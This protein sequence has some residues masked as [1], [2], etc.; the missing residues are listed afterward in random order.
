MAIITPATYAS[1]YPSVSNHIANDPTPKHQAVYVPAV[2]PGYAK[3][4]YARNW[5]RPLPT[6][7][8]SG[9]LNFLDP[10]NSLLRLSHALSSAGQALNQTQPCIL[11]AR[12]RSATVLI[13]D[14]GGYQIASGRLRINGD[15]DRLRILRWLEQHSDYAMTLDVPTGSVGRPDYPFTCTRDCL[16]ATLDHLDFFQR[17]RVA[18]E[19]SFLNVLQGNNLKEADAWY[20]AVKVYNFEGWAFAGVLRQDLYALCHR[21]LTMAHENQ[22]QHKKWIHILGTGTL[23]VAVLL[24][25]LQRSINRWINPNLR[26][27]YDTSSAFRSLRWEQAY[28]FPAFSSKAMTMQ[29][30]TVPDHMRFL[31]SDV[32]W[33]WPSPLGDRMIMGDVCFRR[34]PALNNRR[35]QQSN[36]Y[37]VHHNLGALCWGI[38]TANRVFDAEYVTGTHS[39]A[40][41]VARAAWAIDAV[42]KSRCFDTLKRHRE[43]FTRFTGASRWDHGDYDRDLSNL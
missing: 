30:E 1:E 10:S 13:G 3:D 26:I 20:D 36:H 6:G 21:I 35:D 40:R 14:S 17:N 23:E 4:V 15:H 42:L 32:R 7:V 11:T 28:S 19:T 5:T 2:S 38:A 37:I 9:D 18:G 8:Q 41:P 25:A 34:S 12:D 27:S 22:I 43:D 24:T 29:Q 31:G 39:I 33:P 16:K